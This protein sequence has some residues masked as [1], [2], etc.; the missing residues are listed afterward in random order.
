M[1]GIWLPFLIATSQNLTLLLIVISIDM[2]SHEAGNQMWRPNYPLAWEEVTPKPAWTTLT[3]GVNW[4]NFTPCPMLAWWTVSSCHQCGVFSHFHQCK[5]QGD[6]KFFFLA[7]YVI[8][9]V[10]LF[11]VLVLAEMI[12]SI[13]F[14]VAY[15]ALCFGTVT[16]T[17]LIT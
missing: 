5:L 13:F 10:Q 1:S 16:K 7:A 6:F 8:Q 9:K 15:V 2:F 11:S 17:I 14:V 3:H 12:E 4:R